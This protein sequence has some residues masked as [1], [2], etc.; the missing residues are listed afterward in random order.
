MKKKRKR[1]FWG[2]VMCLIAIGFIAADYMGWFTTIY[3]DYGMELM[4][5]FAFVDAADTTPVE[6]VAVSATYKGTDALCDCQNAG[7]ITR[8]TV[9]GGGF[10]YTQT[11]L[12]KKP[13]P[14]QTI[15]RISEKQID[16]IF[17]HPDYITCTKTLSQAEQD[18]IC[19]I[20]LVPEDEPCR[21][22]SQPAK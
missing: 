15:K 22:D 4:F 2:V 1:I 9:L 20:M 8:A 5:E 16:F 19:T 18:G 7:G 6:G 10:G 14:W 21:A 17:R 12:F 11:L 3:K 13:S